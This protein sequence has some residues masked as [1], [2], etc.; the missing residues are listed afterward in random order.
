MIVA[1][2]GLFSYLFFYTITP[3]CKVTLG[4]K[5]KQINHVKIF[6]FMVLAG[7]TYEHRAE[8]MIGKGNLTDQRHVYQ[9][10]RPVVFHLPS[11]MVEDDNACP[12]RA[13]VSVH[14]LRQQD[15][16]CR[17]KPNPPICCQLSTLGMLRSSGAQQTA[18]LQQFATA[19]P[20]IKRYGDRYQR[21]SSFA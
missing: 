4:D 6:C 21:R 2:P 10:L 5:P 3:F 7:I 19:W 9:I 12:H 20:G 13:G 15:V 18:A 1:L 16:N 17:G 11:A 14:F 8:L